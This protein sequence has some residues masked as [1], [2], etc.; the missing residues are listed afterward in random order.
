MVRLRR[1]KAVTI[2]SIRGRASGI[3]SELAL[4]AGMRFA[5]GGMRYCRKFGGGAGFVPGGGPVAW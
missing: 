5:S 3:G 2:V 1:L 4:A